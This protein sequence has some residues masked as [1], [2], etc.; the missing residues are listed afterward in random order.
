[1]TEFRDWFEPYTPVTEIEQDEF[2]ET[3]RV[4]RKEEQK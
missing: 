2:N 1:M 4:E 3:L